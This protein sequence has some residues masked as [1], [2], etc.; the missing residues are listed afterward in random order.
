MNK[1][2]LEVGA[3]SVGGLAAFGHF[4]S[5]VQPIL[6]DFSYMAAIIIAC[7]TIYQKGK[8]KDKE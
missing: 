6:A 7:V 8:N 2:A 3:V 4:C 1:N 5:M